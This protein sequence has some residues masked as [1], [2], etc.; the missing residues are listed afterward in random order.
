MDDGLFFDEDEP[1]EYKLAVQALRMCKDV[2]RVELACAMGD[3]PDFEMPG[4]E[5]M[6]LIGQKYP[7]QVFKYAAPVNLT[8]LKISDMPDEGDGGRSLAPVVLLSSLKHLLIRTVLD[9][10]FFETA[11]SCSAEAETVARLES[12]ELH[13]AATTISYAPLRA[14]V[15]K[16][17]PTLASLSLDFGTFIESDPWEVQVDKPFFLPHLHSLFLSIAFTPDLFLQFTSP[18]IPLRLLHV[19]Y[20]PYL[21]DNVGGLVTLLRAQSATLEQVHI[22]HTPS[23]GDPRYYW[24]EEVQEEFKMSL[25]DYVD[26]TIVCRGL[27]VAH[28][29]EEPEDY[30][31]DDEGMWELPSR[32]DEDSQ[33]GYDEYDEWDED[34][35][36][37]ED[38]QEEEGGESASSE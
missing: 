38:D 17:E 7:L 28:C 15:A 35:E 29:I 11:L 21:Y 3:Y 1:S 4:V 16:F 24:P 19:G 8:T 22:A 32:Y 23:T 5:F 18:H 6:V 2:R 34:S 37:E 30:I 13:G 36:E 27:G 25:Q 31:A 26:L 12:L 10:T 20:C 14:F 33:D 9:D